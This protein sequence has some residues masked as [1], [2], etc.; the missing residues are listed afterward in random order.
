M[1]LEQFKKL[2]IDDIIYNNDTKLIRVVTSYLLNNIT[3]EELKQSSIFT[4]CLD[5]QYSDCI[6][7]TEIEPW[8]LIDNSI[9]P[10]DWYKIEILEY[11][12]RK[13][14]YFISCKFTDFG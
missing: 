3:D 14:E 11:R 7:C 9:N 12:L 6:K 10:P 4:K 5:D 1:N 8:T 2:R 13:L